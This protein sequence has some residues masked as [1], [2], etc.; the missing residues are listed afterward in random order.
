MCTLTRDSRINKDCCLRCK[1]HIMIRGVVSH[2]W[3]GFMW[4]ANFFQAKGTPPVNKIS[5]PDCYFKLGFPEFMSPA[6]TIKT[7]KGII[8]QC[9]GY[10]LFVKYLS[11]VY[12][13]TGLQNSSRLLSLLQA[14]YDQRGC[15]PCVNGIDVEGKIILGQRH[16]SCQQNLLARLLFQAGVPG[17]HVDCPH[18]RSCNRLC[19]QCFWYI[20][21]LKYPINLRTQTHIRGLWEFGQDELL[22]SMNSACK[23]TFWK[24]KDLQSK[25]V[26]CSVQ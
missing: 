21:F 3:T 4:K 19:Q 25:C 8:R 6:I 12:A 18:N 7:V 13:H 10:I 23:S 15:Q 26:S 5:Q 17:F 11:D 16:S 22:I 20:L 9:F 24:L 2:V 1:R 14:P